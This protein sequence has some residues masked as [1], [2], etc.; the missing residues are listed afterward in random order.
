MSY[1]YV[2]ISSELGS[3]EKVAEELELIP[4]VEEIYIVYGIYDIVTKVK[5]TDRNELKKLVFEKI[6]GIEYIKT[7]ETLETYPTMQ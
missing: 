5:F 7:T 2:M 6:R 1:A 4:Q 3:E